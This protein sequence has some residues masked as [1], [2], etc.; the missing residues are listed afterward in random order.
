MMQNPAKLSSI[1]MAV[2]L[3]ACQLGYA[4]AQRA[5]ASS[6]EATLVTVFSFERAV[7]RRCIK[8]NGQVVKNHATD[9]AHALRLTFPP[10]NR[11]L[12]IRTK[13]F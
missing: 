6:A 11:K 12:S 13:S 2:G 5:G 7:E 3:V 9:G 8:G 4:I 1:A 10:Y